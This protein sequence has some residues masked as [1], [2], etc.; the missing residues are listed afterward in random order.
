MLELT[1]G[2]ILGAVESPPSVVVDLDYS[3]FTCPIQTIHEA[4]IT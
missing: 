2:V 1:L 4:N 3:T